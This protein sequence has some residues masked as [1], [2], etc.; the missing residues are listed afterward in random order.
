MMTQQYDNYTPE[1]HEVWKILFERQSQNLNDKAC[2]EYLTCLQL[3][4]ANFHAQQIPRFDDVANM[5]YQ[6]TGWGIEVV[7]GIIPVEEFAGLLANR[8]FPS[9]TWLRRRDQ[10][11]YL[12][13]PDMFHD[14]FGHMP[15]L[16]HPLFANFMEAFGKLGCQYLDQAEV[17]LQL[18]RLYW[19]TIEFGVIGKQ[20]N[21]CKIY[22]AGIISSYGETNH[23]YE[24]DVK[25][26]PFDLQTV[27]NT[28]F[29]TDQIQTRYF[30]INSFE[31]LYHAIETLSKI[32][33]S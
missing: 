26:V 19:F 15:L 8:K 11:D 29:R 22:G 12:E 13:E 20:P 17:M 25:I 14:S 18:Q 10:L 5:L 31:Q 4:K 30:K 33:A 6:Q 16:M 9:S 24:P 21:E 28:N 3:M 7:K 2:S 27:I 23:I 32:Y 1:S